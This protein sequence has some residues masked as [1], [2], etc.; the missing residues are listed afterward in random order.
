MKT[1]GKWALFQFLSRWFPPKKSSERLLLS[2][3]RF[4]VAVPGLNVTALKQMIEQTETDELDCDQVFVLLDQYAELVA[5]N[6]DPAVLLPQVYRHL[7][8]CPDCQEEL[9]ALL[10]AIQTVTK[11]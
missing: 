10:L 2:P 9:T 11:T 4:K 3:P 8:R 7:K 6:K 5:Q 1:P